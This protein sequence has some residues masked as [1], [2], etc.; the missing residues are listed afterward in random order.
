[1]E[2]RGQGGMGVVFK[3]RHRPTGQVVALKVLPPSF[4]RDR[5]AVLR[6]R[7]EVEVA[8]RLDHPNIVKALDASE[9]RGVHFLAMEFIEG[10][11]LEALVSSGGPLPIDLALHCVIQAARG[12][13]AAHAQGIVHRDI[14]P[15][16]LMLASS[17][18]VQVLDLG[19]A[20][21]MESTSPSGPVGGRV[22]DA[23]RRL[24][25][26]RRLH[27]PRAGRRRQES[28]PSGRHLQPGLYALLSSDGPAAVFGRDV[29]EEVDGP[30]ER[31]AP[32]L[33]AART[34]VASGARRRVPGHDGEAAGERPQ[35]MTAVIEA[36]RSTAARRP[37]DEEESRA[38]LTT[39]AAKVFKRA[40][41]R[42]RDL[43]R[44]PSVF[45]RPTESDGVSF[46]PDLRL[47][48]LITDFRPDAPMKELPEEKLPPKLPRMPRPRKQSRPIPALAWW[49]IAVLVLGFAGYRLA[50]QFA[51]EPAAI[52][53]ATEKIARSAINPTPSSTQPAAAT[54]VASN[55]V[56]SN[57]VPAK[58]G[59]GVGPVNLTFQQG[60]NGYVGAYGLWYTASD[61]L[62][63]GRRVCGRAGG[64]SRTL[65]G[66]AQFQS[67]D[68]TG[69]PVPMPVGY[70]RAAR[71]K[72]RSC[73]SSHL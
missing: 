58:F 6:F 73:E 20:R 71:S 31:P 4:G 13:A 61:G 14:K 3:A 26:D 59:A 48:D 10:Q 57:P 35:S 2:K 65:F 54:L 15:A 33:V 63:P 27:R 55:P 44:N 41:P 5:E 29:A 62:R 22:V 47:E 51:S 12:M 9:D 66:T 50:P 72:L 17:G 28:R 46:N 36:S 40:A 21:V 45:A 56:T 32:R 68:S 1:M 39:Y 52:A 53:P 64:T 25:G 69:S 43:E 34:D 49:A 24:H 30:P 67:F 38:G 60:A 42:R 19:L 70:P 7:R 16:N 11:D 18:V 8:A 23:N 37:D